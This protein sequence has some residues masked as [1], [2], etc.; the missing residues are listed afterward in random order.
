VG[1]G[2]PVL[3]LAAYEA[4]QRQKALN[5]GDKAYAKK[6]TALITTQQVDAEIKS[7]VAKLTS[8]IA[9]VKALQAEDA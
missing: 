2:G 6:F 4:A 1:T 9:M 3:P 8:H 7:L 5:D